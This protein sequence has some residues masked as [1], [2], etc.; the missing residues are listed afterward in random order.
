MMLWLVFLRAVI[1][2]RGTHG[3]QDIA[4]ALTNNR[5]NSCH[6][7]KSFIAILFWNETILWT[8][9]YVALTSKAPAKRSQHAN[10]TSRNIVGLNRLRAFSHRVATCCEVLGVVGSNLTIFKLEPTTPNMSQH[11]GQT[12]ATC[13][14]QQCCDM[15]GWHVAIVWPRLNASVRWLPR[16]FLRLNSARYHC[17]PDVSIN[18]ARKNDAINPKK[19]RKPLQ[20]LKGVKSLRYT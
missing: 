2:K 16:V 12:H 4:R 11:G 19:K 7:I 8:P 1:P 14:T 3:K 20:H 10:A 15:L 17:L 6:C 13:C 5:A 18:R 9:K